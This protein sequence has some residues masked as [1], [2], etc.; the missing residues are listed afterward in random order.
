[1][2]GPDLGVEGLGQGRASRR[3]PRHYPRAGGRRGERADQ[4]DPGGI[5]GHRVREAISGRS[6]MWSRIL[7]LGAAL[8]M[9]PLGARAADLVVWW[10]KGFYPQEDQAVR[11]IIA[12]F[13]QETGKQVEL[14]QPTQ[15]ELFEKAETAL[16]AGQPPDFLWGSSSESWAPGWAYEDRLADLDGVLGPV[17]DLFDADAIEA[18]TLLNGTTGRRGLYALP[19]GRR[20]QLSPCLEQPPRAGGVQTRRHPASNGTPFGRSGAIRSSRRCARPWAATTFGAWVYRCRLRVIHRDELLQFQLAHKALW[21]T[22]H[23]RPAG[24]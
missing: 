13:E 6:I 17:L 2:L 8:V 14:V 15:D 11:E 18:A 7:I 9:G 3:H 20:L 24:R 22:R 21:I 10:E 4:A 1:M 23:G 12:A 19:M 16:Q 5:A